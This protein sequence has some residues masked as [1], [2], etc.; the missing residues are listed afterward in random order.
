MKQEDLKYTV[1]EWES[2]ICKNGAPAREF[3]LELPENVTSRTFRSRKGR[4][5][6][7]ET[8]PVSLAYFYLFSCAYPVLIDSVYFRILCRCNDGRHNKLLLLLD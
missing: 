1:T 8:L 4:C 2:K 6:R 5:A 7:A 3:Y